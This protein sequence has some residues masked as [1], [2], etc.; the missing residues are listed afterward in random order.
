MSESI[1]HRLQGLLNRTNAPADYLQLHT[2]RCLQVPLD[3]HPEPG[4]RWARAAWLWARLTRDGRANREIYQ[5]RAIKSIGSRKYKAQHVP[6]THS[7]VGLSAKA[8]VTAAQA[9]RATGRLARA[10]YQG[11]TTGQPIARPR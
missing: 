1:S 2:I 11:G 5:A 9:P 6:Q 7:I 4:F 3:R 10:L 8:R